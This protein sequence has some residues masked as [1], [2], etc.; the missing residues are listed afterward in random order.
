MI[1]F[2]EMVPLMNNDYSQEFWWETGA[3]GRA[4]SDR[5]VEYCGNGSI[6]TDFY[7]KEAWQYINNEC[8]WDLEG[9]HVTSKLYSGLAAST[10]LG[11]TYCLPKFG[12]FTV[13]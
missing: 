9:R 3:W 6:N 2:V 10:S 8:G 4:R 13:Q 7:Y 12:L 11:V 1:N 5:N